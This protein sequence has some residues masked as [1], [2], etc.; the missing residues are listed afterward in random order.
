M[1]TG[2]G[3]ALTVDREIAEREDELGSIGEPSVEK[4]GLIG[5]VCLTECGNASCAPSRAEH[6]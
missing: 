1:C 3:C 5:A 6:A 2:H 4:R